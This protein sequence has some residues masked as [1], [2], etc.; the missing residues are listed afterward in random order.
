VFLAAPGWRWRVGA[1]SAFCAAVLAGF[2]ATNGFWMWKLYATVGSPTYPFFNSVFHSPYFPAVEMPIA[3]TNGPWPSRLLP[4]PFPPSSYGR[5]SSM[6]VPF[7]D[8]RLAL[9]LVL[10]PAAVAARAW[11]A[12]RGGGTAAEPAASRVT[13]LLAAFGIVSYL[14]WDERFF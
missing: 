5:H 8:V 6:E 7:A 11:R 14:I 10:I 2:L 4:V 13:W 9:L 3:D 12:G 1:A